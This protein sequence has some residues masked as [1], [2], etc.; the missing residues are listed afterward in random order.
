MKLRY[1][2]SPILKVGNMEKSKFVILGLLMS[3]FWVASGCLTI[4]MDK[5]SEVKVITTPEGADVFINDKLVGI[6]P[7]KIM[8]RSDK[9]Q[10]IRVEKEGFQA[11]SVKVEKAFYLV[12]VLADIIVP[13]IP[14][15]MQPFELIFD[16]E[17]VIESYFYYGVIP[18]IGLNLTIDAVSGAWMVVDVE[19]NEIR[20]DL[21][22]VEENKKLK[23]KT[24]NTN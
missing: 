8:V 1:E 12:A 13:F 6:S 24:A 4:A 19:N 23:A 3:T 5:E 20:I 11:K 7:V 22:P 18:W 10:I 21:E 17:C 9:E 16:E 15:I 14:F 2:Y